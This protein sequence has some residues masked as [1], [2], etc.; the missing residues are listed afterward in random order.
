MSITGVSLDISLCDGPIG[1][2][3]LVWPQD[4]GAECTFLGRTREESHPVY[5]PL[6]RLEY[7]AYRPMAEKVLAELADKAISR[8]SCRAVRIAHSQGAVQPGQASVAIQ[9]ATAH[10]AEAFA[11]CRFLIDRLKN[12]LPIWKRQIWAQ[13][14]S[15]VDGCPPPSGE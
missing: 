1:P 9:V 5:G 3:E 11:A 10:R 6:I 4:C 13:G 14:E 2:I 7:E 15:F 12:E 8:F